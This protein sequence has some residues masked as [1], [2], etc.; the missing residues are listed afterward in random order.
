MLAELNKITFPDCLINK[1][2]ENLLKPTANKKK[3]Y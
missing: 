1:I 3:T 2:S